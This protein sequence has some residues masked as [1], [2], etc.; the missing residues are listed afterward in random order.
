MSSFYLR[1]PAVI[2]MNTMPDSP[3][4]RILS[5]RQSKITKPSFIP[6]ES[7]YSNY[8]SSLDRVKY[9][10]GTGKYEYI[11]DHEFINDI[12]SSIFDHGLK[13]N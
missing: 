4:V 9:W 11:Q 7:D 1:L 8:K 3:K 6:S 5:W 12:I 2:A 10:H 13:T